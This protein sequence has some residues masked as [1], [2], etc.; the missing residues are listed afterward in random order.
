MGNAT[1]VEVIRD[2]TSAYEL[3]L[4]Q[5]PVT[6]ITSLVEDASTLTEGTDFQV[7]AGVGSLDR[8]S[9]DSITTWGFSKATI[10]YVAGYILPD[11]ADNRTLPYDIEEA[12]I[13]TVRARMSELDSTNADAEIRSESLDGIY[14]ASYETN[15]ATRFS[16]NMG[17][18]QRAVALLAKYRIP[19]I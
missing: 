19:M 13:Y 14:S 10:T 9:T 12:C 7:N 3:F 16:S 11:D 4:S 2:L 15:G 6:S 5:R 8:L 1:Y 18:P 17:L